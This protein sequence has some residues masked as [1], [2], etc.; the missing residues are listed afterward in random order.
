MNDA[1]LGDSDCAETHNSFLMEGTDM[2]NFVRDVKEIRRRASEKI[3]KVQSP[4]AT[5][6]TLKKQSRF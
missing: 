4:P 1:T 3:E 5:K 2:P 6:E